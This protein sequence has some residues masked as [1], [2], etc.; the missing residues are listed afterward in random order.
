MLS[1]KRS[2]QKKLPPLKPL[3]LAT[4]FLA[5]TAGIPDVHAFEIETGNP[6]LRVRWD[7]TLKYS[8]A[9]RTKSQ[10]NKLTEGQT[11]LNQ[12]DGDRNFNKGLISN[13]LDLLSEMDITY[14]NFGARVSGAA[15]YDDVYNQGNDNNDPTRS[16]S[17]SVRYDAFTDDTRTLHGRKGEL[18]DAFIFGKTEI[19]DMPVTGRVGQYAMQWGE[20]LFYGMNGIA[21]GMAPIDVVKGL[22]VPNTQFKEL[23]RPVQ[24]ISG[25]LQLT[26]DVSIGAYY[27]FEWEANRLP[28][29]GSYFSSSD[30]FGDGN[31]RMFIGAPLFPGAQPL[32]FYHGNDKEAKDSGQGGIQL[33]WRTESV[34][35]GL[36]AIRFHDKSPQLNVRPDFANLNPQSGKAGEYY[37]VYP[38]GIEAFGASFSTT[39]GNYN[40]AGELSTR[41]NQ[42]LASTSQRTLAVGEA[43]NND[44][45]PLYAT[46]RTLH[47][48]I[49]WLSSMEPN[50]ISQE[51]TFLGEIAWNRVMSVTKNKDAFDPNADRDATSL[52]V[53]YEPMYRQFLSGLDVSVPVGFSYTNG[54]SGALGTGFGADHGGD[55]NIGIKGNYLNTWSLGLTY[56]HYYGPE[57]TFLDENNHYTFEQPLKDRDFIAFTVS[58]TF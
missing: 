34:D 31:E 26:P 30:N 18:L 4:S 15:W 10:S 43:I 44:S 32:A 7:N 2:P 53:V 58:R 51:A 8:A 33:R 21:G 50:F 17:Y 20:S 38:E 11:A 3:A 41:W 48:N 46:G 1:C 29:A 25:Q 35:W 37:W 42:P 55:I 56:T 12:D 14:Q 28:G 5:I 39:L 49:S 19:G 45:D 9:W 52:R 22:S 6:D 27:Q 36:Y 54:A 24:Q 57:N 47:A 16:N 23:I 13:R 40:I